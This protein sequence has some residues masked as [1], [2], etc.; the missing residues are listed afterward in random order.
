MTVAPLRQF[1]FTH[2]TALRRYQPSSRRAVATVEGIMSRSLG[3]ARQPSGI[4]PVFVLEG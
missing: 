2:G 3:L 1:C 4:F